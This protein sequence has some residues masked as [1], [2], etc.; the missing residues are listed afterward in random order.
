MQKF[1]EIGFIAFYVS[2]TIGTALALYNSPS[3]PKEFKCLIALLI[4]LMSLYWIFVVPAVVTYKAIKWNDE[5]VA[6]N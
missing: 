3:K 2:G 4:I 5:D 6:K 1:I